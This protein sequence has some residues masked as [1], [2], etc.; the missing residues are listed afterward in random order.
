MQVPQRPDSNLPTQYL[1]NWYLS[2]L[3]KSQRGIQQSEICFTDLHELLLMKPNRGNS[4]NAP[5][6]GHPPRV[7]ERGCHGGFPQLGKRFSC[8]LG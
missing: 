2:F 1:R 7:L 3:S 5:Y 8:H 6:T 4:W